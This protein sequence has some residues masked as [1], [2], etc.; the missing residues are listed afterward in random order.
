VLSAL[1]VV[2]VF[3]PI[4]G[5]PSTF[6]APAGAIGRMVIN[7][8]TTV[9]NLDVRFKP[10]GYFLQITTPYGFTNVQM[11]PNAD[12]TVWRTTE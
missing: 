8:D 1:L 4:F 5:L 12:S 3:L 11:R 9:V 10:A 2:C 7:E 6:K